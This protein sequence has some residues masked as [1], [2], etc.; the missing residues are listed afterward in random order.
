[1]LSTGVEEISYIDLEDL[2]M[3]R[4]SNIHTNRIQTIPADLFWFNPRIQHLNFN[5]NSITSFAAGVFDFRY[6]LVSLAVM[7]TTCIS[8]DIVNNRAG[9]IN[10]VTRLNIECPPA[11]LFIAS[12]E[13]NIHQ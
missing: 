1:M 7:P 3:L 8:A 4:Q 2:P 6:D 11:G 10:L 13:K 9:V 12:E 5:S